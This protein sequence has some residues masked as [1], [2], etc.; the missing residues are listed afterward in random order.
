MPLTL[1]RGWR[2]DRLKKAR[3][4]IKPDLRSNSIGTGLQATAFMA[5][6]LSKAGL[7]LGASQGGSLEQRNRI[8]G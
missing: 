4:S 5:P 3:Q 6:D 2:P 8:G 7:P 1:I